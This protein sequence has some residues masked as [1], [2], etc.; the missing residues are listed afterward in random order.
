MTTKEGVT[1]VS[2]GIKFSVKSFLSGSAN[3]ITQTSHDVANTFSL[4]HA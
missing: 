2:T 1:N 4:T 3:L